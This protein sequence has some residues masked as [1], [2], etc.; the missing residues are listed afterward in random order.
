MP[1]RST[2]T[3]R[4]GRGR[5]PLDDDVSGLHEED[6]QVLVATLGNLAELGAIARRH[7]LSDEAEPNGPRSSRP[8]RSKVFLP[9]SRPIVATGSDDC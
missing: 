7:L 5:P 2:A 1:S 4:Y 9:M 8:T 6:A 3:R